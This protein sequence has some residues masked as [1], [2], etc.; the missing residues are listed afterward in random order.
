MSEKQMKPC[1]VSANNFGCSKQISRS[2]VLW[3]DSYGC[4][5]IKEMIEERENENF[6]SSADV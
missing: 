2:E 5:K 4:Q 6:N 3:L 1:M